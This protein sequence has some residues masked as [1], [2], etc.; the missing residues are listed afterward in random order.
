MCLLKGLAAAVL[1]QCTKTIWEEE[2]SLNKT[3]K[4]YCF[5]RDI[6]RFWKGRRRCGL[7]EQC[8]L[9]FCLVFLFAIV[10]HCAWFGPRFPTH[11]W[12]SEESSRVVEFSLP[13]PA[14]KWL[15]QSLKVPLV[16]LA[17]VH[18]SK[19]SLALRCGS[20]S[21]AVGAARLGASLPSPFAFHCILSSEIFCS[22]S[23]V[24]IPHS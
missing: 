9:F 2:V 19:V 16:W 11:F 13:Y 18:L 14:P 5:T 15:F 7:P 24:L 23:V 6:C 12:L 20:C 3:R 4:C 17:S 10:P 21:Q 22:W 1:K 8:L